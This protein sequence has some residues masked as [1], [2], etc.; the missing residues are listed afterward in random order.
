MAEDL[1]LQLLISLS[2]FCFLS[3][4]PYMR[5]PRRKDK[6]ALCR[7]KTLFCFRNLDPVHTP[8][9]P[10][11]GAG[12]H[13]S[14]LGGSGDMKARSLE[15]RAFQCDGTQLQIDNQVIDIVRTPC[16]FGGHRLWF[17]CVCGRHVSALYSPGGRPWACRHCYRLSYATRH[18]IPRDR[19]LLEP[20]ASAAA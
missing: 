20:S 10:P 1:R 4:Y 5:P 2:Y 7:A 19:H 3:F 17:R 18:A 15:W 6:A 13:Q 11:A 12:W 9:R 8:T 16:R 14:R